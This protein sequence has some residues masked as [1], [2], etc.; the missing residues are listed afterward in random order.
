MDFCNCNFQLRHQLIVPVY[1]KLL[2]NKNHTTIAKL[3]HSQPVP[4][5]R[6]PCR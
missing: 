3:P 2:I 5:H 1:P 6:F 4:Y